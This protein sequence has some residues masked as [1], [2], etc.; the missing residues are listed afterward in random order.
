[1]IP[2]IDSINGKPRIK[3]I[4]SPVSVNFRAFPERVNYRV[5]L[6]VRVPKR[7][8][9]SQLPVNTPPRSTILFS[10]SIMRTLMLATPLESVHL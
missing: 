2:C 10:A 7:I 8:G 5:G 4:A 1:M 6:F 9:R 3:P